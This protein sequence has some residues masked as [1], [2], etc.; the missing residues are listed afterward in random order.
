MPVAQLRRERPRAFSALFW[1]GVLRG[2]PN[3]C[4][5]WLRATGG[6]QGHGQL[7]IGGCLVYAHRVAFELVK[8]PIPEGCIVRHSCDN[9]P[10]CNPAHLLAGTQL[11]NMRDA[12]ERRRVADG[13]RCHFACLAPEDVVEIRAAVASGC[14]QSDLADEFG[15]HKKT[16]ASAVLGRS[17]V[18]AGGPR[19]KALPQRGERIWSSKLCV[20]EVLEI[21]A[22]V[23]RGISQPKLAK[24]YGVSQPT[25]NDIAHRR[26]WRHV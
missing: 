24:Q 22:A 9:P 21:R 2:A 17:W 15:V 14:L 20:G 3:E 26:S 13:E 4:W 18:R 12:R 25:I 8:G 16:I 11:D 10:C 23:A 7:R 19:R 5:P 1:S 6:R